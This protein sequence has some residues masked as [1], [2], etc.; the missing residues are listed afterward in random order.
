[1]RTLCFQYISC[2]RLGNEEELLLRRVLHEFETAQEDGRFDCT[3]EIQYKDAKLI[4][5]ILIFLIWCPI[6]HNGLTIMCPVHNCP[7]R[8]GKWTDVLNGAWTDPRNPQLSC[9]HTFKTSKHVGAT[10]EDDGKFVR[11]FENVFLALNENGEVMAWRF[12]KSTSFSEI[13]DLLKD[14]KCRLDKTGVTLEM[15]LVDDCCHVRNFTNK[16]FRGPKFVWI[17]FM[18][19]WELYTQFLK[20][21]VSVQNFQINFLWFFAKTETS[22][23]KEKCPQLVP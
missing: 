21:A 12:T 2:I 17:C 9:D 11:Q 6:R 15:V 7:L 16:Y 3:I 5:K 18:R 20:V 22:A 4:P 8:V 13:Y 10:R 19:A 1:M 23:T 14:L